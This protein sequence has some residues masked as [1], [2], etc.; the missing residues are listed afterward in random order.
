MAESE[1]IKPGEIIKPFVTQEKALRLIHSLYGLE[2]QKVKE[3]NSYDDRNFLFKADHVNDNPHLNTICDDGYVLKITNSK[4]SQESAFFDAQKELMFHL[5]EHGF[6]VPLP[7]PNKRGEFKSLEEMD[8]SSSDDWAANNM[9]DES[10][11]RYMVRVLRFIPGKIFDEIEPWTTDHFFQCGEYIGRMDMSLKSFHHPA[12]D[13]RNLIWF[14]SNV[15]KL[16]DFLFAVEDPE[17]L[18]LM[19]EIIQA[20]NLEVVPHIDELEKGIIHGDVNEQN[21]LVKPKAQN[22]LEYEMVSVIDFGDTQK[23]P[24]VF[25]LAITIMYMMLKSSEVHANLAGG[26]VIAGYMKHRKIPNLEM[27][28]LR[29]CIASRF[30]QSLILGAYSYQQDP[31]NE[32][33][34]CSARTGWKAVEEFWRYP[35]D[36]LH[37]DWQEIIDSYKIE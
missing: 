27:N 25:E 13:T 34:L 7:I 6:E 23:N 28:V 21:I 14:L 4:D 32:Y 37:N 8:I 2:T 22:S 20:F 15:P 36:Q 30:A 10:V 19:T 31:G 18:T 17:R 16:S 5:S 12:F 9:G 24:L 3:L 33:L 35:K 11:R 26:H 29:T 1:T